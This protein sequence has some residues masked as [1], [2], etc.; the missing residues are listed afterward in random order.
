TFPST[1]YYRVLKGEVPPDVF[2]DKIVYVGATS[3]LLH[4][5]FP[6]AFTR[7]VNM[8]GVEIHANVL[9]NYVRGDA[10]R[11]IPS[12]ISTVLAAAAAVLGAYLVV[13]LPA[14]RASLALRP[15][16]GVLRGGGGGGGAGW[17]RGPWRRSPGRTSGCAAWRVPSPW[18]LASAPP[19]WSTSSAS[20]ARSAASRSSSPPTS[21][22]PWC[23]DGARSASPR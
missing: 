2:R 3:P 14:L 5:V 15:A 1:S 20:S 12:W 11:E 7:G 21:C 19:W 22:A 4:D 17:A 9:D 8:P 6:T 23:G 13:R 18:G 10:L 16:W